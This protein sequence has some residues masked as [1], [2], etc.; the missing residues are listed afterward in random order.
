LLEK[1]LLKEVRG[2][3]SQRLASLS[4]FHY[5]VC[6]K[7]FKSFFLSFTKFFISDISSKTVG[8]VLPSS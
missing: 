3:N 2:S 5:E 8:F 4:G 7:I 1:I 6:C